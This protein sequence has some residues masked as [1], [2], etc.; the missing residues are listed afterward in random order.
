[1]PRRIRSLLSVLRDEVQHYAS[2]S[3]TIA[4]RTNLLALNATIEAARSGEAGRGFAVVAQEVKALAAQARS[5]AA[6]F[7]EDVL[8]RLGRG[9]EIAEEMVAEIEGARLIDLAQT[10]VT[11]VVRN[12]YAR[13]VDLRMLATDSLIVRALET[14][15]PE[16]AR[17]AN[18]RLRT[19][20][21]FSPYY[22]NAFVADARGD[23]PLSADEAASVLTHNVS[24]APQYCRAMASDTSDDWYTDEVWQNPWS[25]NRAVLVFV[26][27]VWP[28]SGGGPPLGVCYL[29]F[30]WQGQVYESIRSA[31]GQTGEASGTRISIVDAD[32][33]LVA[34]SWNGRFGDIVTIANT[35]RG[36][37]TRSDRLIAHASAKPWQGFDGLG[38]RC[39]IEQ[40]VPSE[41]QIAEALRLQ[42]AA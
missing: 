25:N 5:N 2:R 34:S 19:L 41:E 7:R 39:V 15:L 38:L 26:S 23:I 8:D 32:N 9:A 12:L 35:A 29:E 42:R 13:S 18:L 11:H 17:A 27:A 24:D 31:V 1:M 22:L 28:A 6:A 21:R 10:I 40:D 36:I 4:G 16:D 33:R 20:L 14:G 3:E 37:E 30:D